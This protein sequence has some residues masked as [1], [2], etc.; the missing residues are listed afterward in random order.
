MPSFPKP[1]FPYTVNVTKEKNNLRKYR[2]TAPGR[3]IPAK[4]KNRLLLA[5]WNIANLGEQ[6]RKPQHYKLIAEIISWFDV[7]AIQECKDDLSGLRGVMKELPEYYQTIFS[8]KG[9]NKERMA[10]LY[11]SRKVK[12]MEKVGEIDFPPSDQ[13]N[14]KIKGINA[15]FTGYDRNPFLVSFKA[16]KMIFILVNVHLYYGDKSAKSIGRRSLE[17]YGVARWA[18][19]RRDSVY[20]YT[21]K[22]F[23]LGD[24][25]LPKTE[26]GDP[27]YKALVAKGMELPDHSGIIYSNITDD[28]QYDQV[29]FFPDMKNLLTGNKGV[30][31]YDGGIFPDL[32]Q[33]HT[34]G[35]FKGYLKYYIS[36]HR[37]MW[38]ELTLS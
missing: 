38:L 37:P 1:T 25:N 15:S 11:D 19:L 30:F 36:D 28:A 18:G 2:D 22:I 17:A 33:Q 20:A 14:I 5:T 21:D 6:E 31:D 13:K 26:P 34:K 9:G 10:F 7:V 24:F 4:S 16:G 35:E 32:F 23:A 8:D 27:V 29:A 3:A 12:V